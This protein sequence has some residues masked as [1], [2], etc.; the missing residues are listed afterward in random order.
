MVASIDSE[1]PL[2]AAR[3]GYPS[4]YNKWK[5]DISDLRNII[6]A[7]R[8][9]CIKNLKS[10]FGLSDEQITQLFPNG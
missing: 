5:S 6:E 1:I 4:S 7:R 8:G 9:Y 3:W 2:T 10:Y